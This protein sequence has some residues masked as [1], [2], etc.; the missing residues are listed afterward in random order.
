MAEQS[1]SVYPVKPALEKLALLSCS[2]GAFLPVF[3]SDTRCPWVEL[4]G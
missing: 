1:R 4:L 2:C 3:A